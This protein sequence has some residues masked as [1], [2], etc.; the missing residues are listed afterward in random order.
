MLVSG[1]LVVDFGID[2]DIRKT[3]NLVN[4][5][6]QVQLRAEVIGD[7]AVFLK[8]GDEISVL[9]YKDNPISVEIPLKAEL[10]VVETMMGDKGNTV[11]QALKPATLE[12]GIV[13]QVPM[14]IKEGDMIR[15]DTRDGK[16]EERV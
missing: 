6:L 9:W 3:R 12:N 11:N 2:D 10:K 13:V 14:F 4:H 1:V 5:I 16:Y 8:E 15:L 7:Q